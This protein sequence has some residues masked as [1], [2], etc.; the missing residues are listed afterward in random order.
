M[1]YQVKSSLNFKE[2][3]IAKEVTEFLIRVMPKAV[4]IH[5]DEPAQEGCSVK[6]IK[7]YHDET[8]VKL[9]ICIT[10]AHCP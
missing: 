7:C 3:A 1:I 5:P 4:V 9:C 8:P 2:E 10:E 6:L